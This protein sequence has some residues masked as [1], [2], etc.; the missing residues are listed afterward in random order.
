MS[1]EIKNQLFLAS[2]DNYSSTVANS[3]K[4]TDKIISHTR[5][6]SSLRKSSVLSRLAGEEAELKTLHTSSLLRP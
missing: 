5:V 1:L 6:H 4:N 3:F 2:N